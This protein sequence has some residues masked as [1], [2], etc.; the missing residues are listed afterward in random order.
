MVAEIGHKRSVIT[1][2]EKMTSL[3]NSLSRSEVQEGD[4]IPLRATELIKSRESNS[5]M[6]AF[7]NLA[8]QQEELGDE[9]EKVLFENIF[10]LYSNL[11]NIE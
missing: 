5:L 8:Q 10:D 1:Q 11:D 9:F 7:S 4:D 6:N 2:N 3:K